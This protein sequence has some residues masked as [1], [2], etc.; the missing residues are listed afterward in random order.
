MW[1][2]LTAS[3]AA[4]WT[5][6]YLAMYLVLVRQ[7]GGSPVWWY[8]GL[9]AI[10]LLPL[11]AAAVGLVSRPVLIVGAVALVVSALLGLLSIGVLLLPSVVCA[12]VAAAVMKPAPPRAEGEPT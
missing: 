4:A 8:V 5:A 1:A 11:I 3:V 10:G 9:V 6:G 7:D 12:V 2:R